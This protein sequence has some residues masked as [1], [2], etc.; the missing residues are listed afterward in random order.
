VRRLEDAALSL[1]RASELNPKSV[2]ALV[3]LGEVRRRQKLYPEAFK[4][5][6]AALLLDADSWQGHFTLGLVHLESGDALRAAPHA[7][8][9]LQLKPD[10]AEAHLLA[11]NVLLGVGQ[12]RRALAEYEEYLRLAPQG[13]YAAPTREMSRKIK[14]ALEEKQAP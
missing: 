12:P 1:A 9:A 7:G 5:L 8:R 10:F 13:E 14:K 3:S 6:E 4:A 2:P 11:G